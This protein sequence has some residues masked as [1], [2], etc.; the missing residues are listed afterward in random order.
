MGSWDAVV[1]GAG[2]AGI[3]AA[4]ELARA[5]K[6]VLLLE[7]GGDL[8]ERRC[9]R[10]ETGKGCRRCIPCQLLSGWGGAGAFC[11]GKLSLSPQV[12][13]FL[14]EFLPRPALR[15]LLDEVD[16]V[17]R[18][19]G[20][21]PEVYGSR[22]PEWQ[23]L[24]DQ[25]EAAGLVL[26][27]NPV[28]HMGTDVCRQVL[29]SLYDEISGAVEIRFH[30]PCDGVE[31]DGNRVRGVWAGAG[32]E[33]APVVIL[34]PGRVG[35]GWI[36]DL[37]ADL[38]LRTVPN[39]VDIG[40]RVE[41]PAEVMDPV[42]SVLY[43]AK[44]YYES[45]TFRDE[46]RTFCMNPRGEVVHEVY[47]DCLTVNGHAY[48][49]ARSPATNFALLVKTA[50]TEPFD[51][52]IAYG[53][54]IARLANLIGG[55]ILVQRLTDLTSG[56]RSTPE[57][58]AKVAVPP[59]LHDA[60]PGDLSFALPHR[61]LT[62]VIETLYALDA[63]CPG[64]AGPDTLLYGVEVKFYSNRLELDDRLETRIQGLYGAGDGVGVSR[65][66]MQASASG[67]WAARAALERL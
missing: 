16:G 51:D 52:P 11:D 13:G 26:V 43:E 36:R 25:A 55:G 42:T 53:R 8:R 33:R 17:W 15:T 12:G 57:R 39:P 66:L 45:P 54:Y 65:G 24:R 32:L 14:G 7:K 10:K 19:H 29:A 3:F 56:R 64:L 30:T 31:V 44:L 18:A 48:A 2:A 34:A 60:T 40:V 67:V 38:G 41:C 47:E 62:D 4:R 37:A 59:T 22:V 6:R 9:P 23:A 58:I 61:H 27:E 63:F 46:V 28:R 20:A 50:F 35:A 49:S 1:V 21:P 5:G